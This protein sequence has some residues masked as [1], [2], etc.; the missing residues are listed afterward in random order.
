M[1]YIGGGFGASVHNV[2]EAAVYGLPTIFGT[3][4]QKSREA[5]ELIEIGAALSI[6][7]AKELKKDLPLFSNTIIWQSSS[8]AAQR[9]VVEN[10][11]A[12][13]KILSSLS[14]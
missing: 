13:E 10:S 6:Q 12:T 5:I 11:G 3:N 2:L 8:E 4:Y 7:N 9:Y 1:A 14:L